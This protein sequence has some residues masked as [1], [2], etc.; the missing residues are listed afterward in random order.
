MPGME[1]KPLLQANYDSSNVKAVE[2]A[3]DVFRELCDLLRKQVEHNL[4]RI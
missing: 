2:A 4:Y 1:T 3:V